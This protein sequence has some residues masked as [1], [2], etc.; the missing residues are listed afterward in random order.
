MTPC[1]WPPSPPTGALA[2]NSSQE[3]IGVE[4]TLSASKYG[5]EQK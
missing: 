4:D 2:D 5:G 1:C 3:V